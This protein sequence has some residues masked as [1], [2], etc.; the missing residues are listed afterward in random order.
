MGW[1]WLALRGWRLTL[2]GLRE[3][4]ARAE[5]EVKFRPLRGREEG[6]IH[7]LLMSVSALC[8]HTTALLTVYTHTGCNWDLGTNW[9][10]K[11]EERGL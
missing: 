7:C 6:S 4:P 1:L 11:E 5:V 3:G 8:A 2:G 10:A 9:K